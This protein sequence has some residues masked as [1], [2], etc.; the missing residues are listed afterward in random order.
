[1]LSNKQRSELKNVV[2]SNPNSHAVI[3]TGL[4]SRYPG[5]TKLVSAQDRSQAT[6]D[7]IKTLNP[8]LDTQI[9]TDLAGNDSYSGRVTVTFLSPAELPP[10]AALTTSLA[11]D[12]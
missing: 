11:S 3:C 8:A 9:K 7:Y 2:D 12:P 1:L 4:T 10:L 5:T 6:C